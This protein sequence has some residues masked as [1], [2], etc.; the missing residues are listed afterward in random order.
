LVKRSENAARDL[1]PGALE[2]MILQ[3]LKRQ[4]LHGYALAQRIK[5]N[6]N[7]VLQ[8]EEGSLYPAL[9]RLLRAALV[10]VKRAVS[11][12]N[13]R[14]RVYSVTPA[15]GKHLQTQVSSFFRMLTGIQRVLAPEES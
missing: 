10:K 12:T 2:M 7:D 4:P 13:G 5:R 3:T 14:I 1:F 6:S 8:I 9:Q 11:V 15:G